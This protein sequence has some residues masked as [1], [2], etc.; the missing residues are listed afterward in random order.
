MEKKDVPKTCDQ[1]DGNYG[2]T[3]PREVNPD[4]HVAL[5]RLQQP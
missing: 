1:I 4:D 5:E 2:K 3:S